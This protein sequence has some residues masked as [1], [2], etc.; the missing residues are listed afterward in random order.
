MDSKFLGVIPVFGGFRTELLDRL[1]ARCKLVEHAAEA[2]IVTEGALAREMFVVR[3]GELEVF[4][5][6][7]HGTEV[8]LAVLREGDCV[9]EMSLI[10][11]QPRSA[12]VRA[13]GN[14]S[15]LVISREDL[16]EVCKGESDA[17]AMLVMNIA[18][19]I[20]RR[21][22]KADALLAE[23]AIEAQEI[24]SGVGRS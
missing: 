8:R 21:L 6:N 9:G 14:A 23:K 24:W 12:S 1:L 3:A 15:L 2:E 5:R 10:D 13:R 7:S 4:K 20:S 17:W 19:E 11:I 18:R 22:R 16:V